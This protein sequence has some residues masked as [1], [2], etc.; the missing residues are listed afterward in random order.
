M[1]KLIILFIFTTIFV[2]ADEK[3]IETIVKPKENAT[4][5]QATGKVELSQELTMYYLKIER[6]YNTQI[7]LIDELK[8][9]VNSLTT[10]IAYR[11]RTI[12]LQDMRITESDRLIKYYENRIKQFGTIERQLTFY[13]S[14]FGF[15]I[16][17]NVA[18]IIAVGCF[19]GG[20]SLANYL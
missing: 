5:N 11:D 9:Q 10:L 1:K 8:F 7:K 15:N 2:Q 18:S 20:Y 12:E 19:I 3:P 16:G 17:V 4:F 14:A 6:A 13:K